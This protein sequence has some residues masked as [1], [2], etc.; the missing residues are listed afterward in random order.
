MRRGRFS[1]GFFG[2]AIGFALGACMEKP[3]APPPD[4]PVEPFVTASP[5]A[6]ASVTAVPVASAPPPTPPAPPTTIERPAS[7]VGTGFDLDKLFEPSK[8][9]AGRNGPAPLV[10]DCEYK[11][12]EAALAA[13]GGPD[14]I[15]IQITVEPT[16]LSP[17]AKG[18]LLATFKNVTSAPRTVLFIRACDDALLAATA[19]GA[20][21]ERADLVKTDWG[22]GVS[23]GCQF[24]MVAVTLEAGGTATASGAYAAKMMK[25]DPA[26]CT[27]SPAGL[28]K[29]GTYDLR[30]VTPLQY[31]E[32]P[33]VPSGARRLATTR[34][35]VGK[36]K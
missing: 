35:E 11:G 17:G 22:C 19:L 9:Q 15:D 23:R 21:G 12:P 29:A 20:D 34:L 5:P 32:K 18:K 7:C 28:L 24:Q 3:P 8:P 2:A 27:E 36:K 25:L 4:A 31:V 1:T 30:V 6:S 33:S 26:P 14:A 16:P 13:L 10:A